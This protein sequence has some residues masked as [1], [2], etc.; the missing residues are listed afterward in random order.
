[1]HPL[2]MAVA[3]Q[4]MNNIKSGQLRNCLA[5]GFQERDLEALIDPRC[6][7]ALVNSPVPW[8]KL[9]VDSDVVQRLM[10]HVRSDDEEGLIRRA[11]TLGASSPMLHQLFGLPPKEVAVRRNM[12][13]LE[14]RKGRWPLLGF[15]EEMRLWAHWLRISKEQGTHP[16]DPRSVLQAA[17]LMTECEPTL[18]LTMIWNQVQYWINEGLV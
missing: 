17:M 15:E 18:N 9:L 3:F 10:A 4:I 1:M 16:K 6:V 13:G 14:H 12:L 5:M 7:G 8:F 11:L 2:N